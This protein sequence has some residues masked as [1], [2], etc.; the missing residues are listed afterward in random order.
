MFQTTKHSN[1]QQFFTK[2][3]DF[4]VPNY[5]L[6]YVPIKSQFFLGSTTQK[7]KHPYLIFMGTPMDYGNHQKTDSSWMVVPIN[8]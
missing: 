8:D 7:M 4:Y 3:R 2:R 1:D 5:S 6:T